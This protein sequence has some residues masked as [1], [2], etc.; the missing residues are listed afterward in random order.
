[1]YKKAVSVEI[2]AGK[3][4]IVASKEREGKEGEY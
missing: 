4:S 3:D 1:M 2:V